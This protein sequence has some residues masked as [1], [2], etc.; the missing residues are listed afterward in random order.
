MIFRSLPHLRFA[1]ASDSG[2]ERL[3]LLVGLIA[4]VGAWLFT[5]SGLSSPSCLFNDLSGYPCPSCG[6][7]RALRAVVAGDFRGAF[8]LNPLVVVLML[9]G[10]VAV[11]YA[12]GV[13]LFGIP[14]W[15][16]R[17]GRAGRMALR[18]LAIGALLANEWFLI[19]NLV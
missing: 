6:G 3:L 19:W 11:L 15:R 18:I 16:P 4:P 8:L 17:L 13:V 1:K 5:R 2:F 7:T 12:A 10:L 9:G 14:P